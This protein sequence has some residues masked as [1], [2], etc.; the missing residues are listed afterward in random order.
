MTLI[1]GRTGKVSVTGAEHTRE[2]YVLN[3]FD[4]ASG[5]V[6]NYREMSEDL[7]WFNMTNDIVLSIDIRAGEEP[8]TTDYEIAAR[9]PA[10]WTATVFADTTG[11]RSTGRPRA[12]V[13]VT[14]RSLFGWR[15]S[16]TVLGIASEG[17]KSAMVSYSLP[18]TSRGTRLTASASWGNVDVIQGPSVEGNVEGTSS[19]YAL[20]LDHPIYADANQKWTIFGE[21]NR[22]ESET[23]FF[24]VTIADT[25]IDTWRAG[26]E[27]ILL[28]DRSVFYALM[29]LGRSS[30]HEYT[31]GERWE[32]NIL[33]GN[34][35]WRFQA[36]E[37]T[38]L[39][40]T[41]AW[42][43][44]I[45]GDD[46]HT[47]QYFYLGHTSGVRGYEND[48]IS[49]ESGAWVNFE[50]SYAIAGPLTSLFA[51]ADAGKLGGET[52]YSKTGLASVGAGVRWPLWP[53]ASIT[54]TMSVP[55][56]RHLGDDIHVNKARFDLAVVAV[57]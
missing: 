5:E 47:S 45:G 16:A 52:A 34:A 32:Q 4:L 30:V 36:T 40:A 14:N 18:L 57:W 44:L 37:K 12:G 54:G 31:F 6:A 10:N 24:A 50:A 15:D 33:T 13:S 51:F 53:G 8:G 27:M 17:S 39:S 41:A 43:S 2:G 38:L 48:V 29:G 55:L 23:D 3:A 11:T 9:E 21:W 19:Y 25:R 42:Q 46:L 20:R 22:Q 35:Y 26:A 7:V 49:A 1:E 28:G 56:V